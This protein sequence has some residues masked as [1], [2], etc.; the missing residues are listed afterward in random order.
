VEKEKVSRPYRAHKD[1]VRSLPTLK[2]IS[3]HTCDSQKVTQSLVVEGEVNSEQISQHL[4][5][6]RV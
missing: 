1:I 3:E 5:R 4:I 2:I 6:N